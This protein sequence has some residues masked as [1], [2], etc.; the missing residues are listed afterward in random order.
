MLKRIF[1]HFQWSYGHWEPFSTGGIRGLY[2]S[3]GRS[4]SRA[5][6]LGVSVPPCCSVM[7]LLFL[8]FISGSTLPPTAVFAGVATLQFDVVCDGGLQGPAGPLQW[9]Q[10]DASMTPGGLEEGDSQAF[11]QRSPSWVKTCGKRCLADFTCF[12]V[13]LLCIHA[14]Q[15][16]MS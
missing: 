2:S 8:A 9:Q 7:A 10:A 13:K 5:A 11:V 4:Q 14:R 16:K 15:L 1:G 6:S 3:P 12:A